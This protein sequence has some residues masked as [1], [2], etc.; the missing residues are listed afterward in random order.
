MD[1]IVAT[2]KNVCSLIT[3]F[4]VVSNSEGPHSAGKSIRGR[5]RA[6]NSKYQSR[7]NQVVFSVFAHQT[8][9][10]VVQLEPGPG[11]RL[12]GHCFDSNDFDLMTVARWPMRP[13]DIQLRNSE[14]VN[15]SVTGVKCRPGIQRQRLL[16]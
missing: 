11:E 14:S 5:G 9:G 7:V 10:S 8:Q 4:P 15:P 1:R 2:R 12:S 6:P 13:A 16:Q 3:D